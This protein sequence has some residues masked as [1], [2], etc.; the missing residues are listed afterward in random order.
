VKSRAFE[1]QDLRRFKLDLEVLEEK[2][3]QD[4]HN[5]PMMEQFFFINYQNFRY[6]PS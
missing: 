3:E 2:L 5:I 4:G 1:K 6:L